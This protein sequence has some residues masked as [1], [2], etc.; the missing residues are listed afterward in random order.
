[1]RSEAHRR[2][3]V[4]VDFEGV[5][6]VSMPVQIIRGSPEYAQACQYFT[7]EVVTI[8]KAALEAGCEEVVICESHGPFNNIAGE[9]L[10]AGCTLIS[11]YPR[12]LLM[13]EGIDQGE[14]MGVVMHG[15]HTG[16]GAQGGVLSHTMDGGR[17]VG[18]WVD[19]KLA[20]ETDFN[21][22]VA[23]EHGVPVLMVTGDQ[24]YVEA[25]R[26]DLGDVE[27]VITKRDISMFAAAHRSRSEVL[28]DLEDCT[29]RAVT[30]AASLPRPPKGSGPVRIEIEFFRRVDAE[31]F[32]WLPTVERSGAN[33]IAFE[34]PS[35]SA[36]SRFLSVLVHARANFMP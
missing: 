8:A 4:T 15:Q 34:S 16:Q 17:F 30:R 7:D 33:R 1:V 19:G 26:A 22:A 32:S 31:L 13:M 25:V 2:L 3:Y 12:P 21:S 35:M 6:L 10:P 24:T 5:A 11:G 18:L 28:S 29:H 23:A 9:R 27:A 14:Y 36:A 20:S